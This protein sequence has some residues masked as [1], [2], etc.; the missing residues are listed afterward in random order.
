MFQECRFTTAGLDPNYTGHHCGGRSRDTE[1]KTI[2]NYNQ[3]Q[4]ARVSALKGNFKI[5]P[6]APDQ[7]GELCACAV[8]LVAV[9]FYD[10]GTFIATDRLILSDVIQAPGRVPG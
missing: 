3:R 7:T 5:L 2:I 9:V 1:S 10:A 8:A 4:R 6:E